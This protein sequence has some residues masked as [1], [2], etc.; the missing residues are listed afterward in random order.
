MTALLYF[1]VAVGAV[2]S[3]TRAWLGDREDRARQAFL[4]LG[5]TIGLAYLSFAL[6]LLPGLEWFRVLYMFAGGCIPMA[7]LLTIDRAFS[8]D[9]PGTDGLVGAVVVGTALVVPLTTLAHALFYLHVPRASVPE[10]LA[11]LFT[12]G[13]FFGVLSR[14]HRAQDEAPL[15]V[16]RTRLRY[17]LA[18]A[19]AAVCFTLLEQIARNTGPPI[20]ASALSITS[21]GVALQGAIPPF[22]AVF[23]GLTLYLLYHTVTVYRLLDLRELLSHAATLLASALLLVVVDG[24]T[25]LWVDTFTAY[26]FHSTFQIFLASLMFLAGYD[27]L[28]KQIEWVAN[29][30]FNSRGQQLGAALDNLR[31]VVPTLIT[32]N[33]LVDVLVNRLHASG[34]VPVC[35]VYLWDPGLDAFRCAAW[36]NASDLRPL[37]IVAAHPFTDDFVGGVPWYARATKQRRARLDPEQEEVLALMDAMRADVTLPFVSGGV[38]LGWLNLTDEDWS[39][40]FSA[41]ELHRVQEVAHLCATVLSNIQDFRAIEEEHRLAALGA[42]A[43]GL[44][45]EIRNP[46]AGMK[47]AVQYLQ[48]EELAEDSQEMLQVILDEVNRLDTVVRQFLVYARPFELER[49]P[50]P[51]NAIVAHVLALVRAQGPRDHLRIREEL[52]GDLPVV[53]IDSA[54]LSQVVLNLVQNA[55]QA[56]ESGGELWIQTRR[57]HGRAGPVIEI[58]VRDTG[59]GIAEDDHEKLFVPFYT[60]KSTGTGLGLAISQRIVQAHGGEIEVLSPSGQGATFIVRLP[61]PDGLD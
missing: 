57:R 27:P 36:R 35:S 46:L 39:D 61:V 52:A 43:T 47:G 20:D 28:R 44:A 18:T 58:V 25:F 26:P 60:T 23:T 22:S 4:G 3:A 33:A 51:I 15:P 7:A 31:R 48:A 2:A 41:D 17:L 30:T 55:L 37:R 59:P 32:T 54:R 12:F 53:P 9:H 56:M 34:R 21:R 14:L 29:R 42:M 11:G 24:I 45:H 40:G 5:W 8:R 49:R 19:G 16:D 13:A 38:V 10:V 50:E 6:S 1:I